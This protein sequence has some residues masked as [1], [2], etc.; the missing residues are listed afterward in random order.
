MGTSLCQQIKANCKQKGGSGTNHKQTPL[1]FTEL[2][3]SLLVVSFC[4][5]SSNTLPPPPRP[6]TPHTQPL[7]KETQPIL[8][9]K[10]GSWCNQSPNA[11]TAG[12]CLC[13]SLNVLL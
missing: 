13:I 9:T 6:H 11:H 4:G 1:V 7:L 10:L 5:K 3:S 8:K 2:H 12:D